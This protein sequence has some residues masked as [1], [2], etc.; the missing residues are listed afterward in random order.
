MCCHASV[1]IWYVDMQIIALLGA[2]MLSV[3]KLSA[4]ILSDIILL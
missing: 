1:F 3:I 2:I 4:I